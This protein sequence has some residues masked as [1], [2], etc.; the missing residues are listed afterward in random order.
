M[1]VLAGKYCWTVLSLAVSPS[2]RTEEFY[3]AA[4]CRSWEE[5]PVSGHHQAFA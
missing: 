3:S 4:P 5:A 2:L 1:F